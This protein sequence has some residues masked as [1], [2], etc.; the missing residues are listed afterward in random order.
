MSVVGL[1]KLGQ[2]LEE[3]ENE[4]SLPVNCKLYLGLVMF[5]KASRDGVGPEFLHEEDLVGELR[6][7]SKQKN[8]Q[9]AT[10]VQ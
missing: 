9:K 3:V 5:T 6:R 7:V 10:K 4:V 1:N 8:C 2:L